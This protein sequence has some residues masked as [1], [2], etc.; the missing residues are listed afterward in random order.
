MVTR[1]QVGKLTA[2][3]RLGPRSLNKENRTVQAIA[4]TG[5]RGARSGYDESLDVRGAKLDRLNS[6]RAPLLDGHDA[7][8]LD[9]I[10]GTVQR[11]WIDGNNL[12]VEV[13]FAETERG[14][15][16]M[17]MVE[18]GELTS[19][20]IGYTVKKYE[21][22]TQ[23]S[24]TRSHYIARDWEVLEVSLVAI[25]FD[26]NAV[27]RNFETEETEILNR[28]QGA[29]TGSIMN[30]AQLQAERTRVREI[31]NLCRAQ[32]FDDLEDSLIERGAT[33]DEARKAVLEE[34]SKKPAPAA[35]IDTNTRVEVGMS[36]SERKRDLIVDT[37]VQRFGGPEAPKDAR[38]FQ[39]RSFL[40]NL[41]H[42]IPRRLGQTDQQFATRAMSSS[43]L[44]YILANV[45]E[46]SIANRLK[47]A[48]P[49]WKSWASQGT[50][51]NFKEHS[52]LKSSAW[53]SLQERQEG[54][55]FQYG[56]LSEDREQVALKEFGVALA[57]TRRMLINDDLNELQNMI[58]QSAVAVNALENSLVYSVLTSNPAMADGYAVF[59]SEHS[60][61]LSAAALTDSTIGEAFKKM[62]EQTS[63]DGRKLNMAPQFLICGPDQEMAA[64]KY[65]A[66][67][68]PAQASNVNPFSQSLQL[69][70]DAEITSNDYFFA[71]SPSLNAGVSLFHLE[72]EESP[73]VE[74]RNRFETENVEIKVA[75]SAVAKAV[76]H[77]GLCKSANAS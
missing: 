26:Q 30:E 51:R 13:R 6:G 67:I 46:K 60:N 29:E 2:D 16:A 21:D 32:G 70:V 66:Q 76:D 22:V 71:A 56:S 53:P 38:I 7:S 61:L 9:A 48:Q 43:D 75:H 25:P 59:S 49:S 74:S 23:K 68:S 34:M 63:I 36:G 54:G 12:M 58:G 8:S 14:N 1:K 35:Q 72:G 73:R 50:L 65:L 27:I 57:F 5:S 55:E 52:L 19:L 45:G 33:V 20:S 3:A 31:K 40:Q 24:D 44:P 28:A 18:R 64:R 42:V 10:L 39:G 77:R 37:L 15:Q 69:V 41:E 62:R 47:L 17:G 4:S 11:A